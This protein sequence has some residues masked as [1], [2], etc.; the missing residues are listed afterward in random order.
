MDSKMT[1]LAFKLHEMA[2]RI[3]EL[4]LIEGWTEEEMAV[5][6]GVTIEEYI[7]CEAGEVDLNFAFLYRCASALSVDVTDIIE[8]TSPRLSRYTLTR[9]AH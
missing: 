2:S 7:A 9:P 5:K 3:R 6:T 4:R 8:G 1:G